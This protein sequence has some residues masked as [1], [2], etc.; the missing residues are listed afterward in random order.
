LYPTG[1]DLIHIQ[2]EVV[3]CLAPLPLYSGGE[4]L[5]S[6]VLSFVQATLLAFW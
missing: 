4:G 3:R 2:A 6:M 1:A 5:G